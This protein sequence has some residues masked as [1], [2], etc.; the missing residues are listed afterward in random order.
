MNI[1]RWVPPIEPLSVFSRFIAFKTVD[2]QTMGTLSKL[3][4]RKC[5]WAAFTQ[6]IGDKSSS[7]GKKTIGTK[8][9]S[10]KKN[11]NSF[12]RIKTNCLLNLV[13]PQQNQ[14]RE[15]KMRLGTIIIST[16]VTLHNYGDDDGF[17]LSPRSFF[18]N[19]AFFVFSC[20]CQSHRTGPPFPDKNVH[21]GIINPGTFRYLYCYS[22]YYTSFKTTDRNKMLTRDASSLIFFYASITYESFSVI[23]LKFLKGAFSSGLFLP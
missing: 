14:K 21:P 17:F 1:V 4:K 12:P 13:P 18:I 9:F 11:S 3:W 8:L 23:I 15:K 22:I 2:N 20:I 16:I 7:S 6:F 19:L 10:F 5:L